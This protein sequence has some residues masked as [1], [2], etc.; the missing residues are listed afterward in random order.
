MTSWTIG[1]IKF[2]R[3]YLNRLT[4]S[5]RLFNDD[6]GNNDVDDDSDDDA[7]DYIAVYDDNDFGKDID[8]NNDNVMIIKL[9]VMMKQ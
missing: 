8:F 7:N 6:N 9:M 2:D 5:I 3:F 1:P 4:I